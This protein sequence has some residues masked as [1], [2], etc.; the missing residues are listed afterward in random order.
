MNKKIYS[1]QKWII[2]SQIHSRRDLSGARCTVLIPSWLVVTRRV[3][4]LWLR[5][6]ASRR[7]EF[8]KLKLVLQRIQKTPI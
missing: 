1:D 2:D 5:F 8:V 7:W 6:F 3:P 4:R